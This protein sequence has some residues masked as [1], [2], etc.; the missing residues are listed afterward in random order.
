MVNIEPLLRQQPILILDG[1]LATELEARGAHLTDALWSAKILLEAP[2]LI[3]EVHLDYFR[4]GADVATTA[5][6]QASFAG[7]ER[8]GLT[9][10]QARALLQRS[11]QLAQ[12]AREL[13]W[14]DTGRRE[15]RI[16]PLVAASIGPYGAFLADGSEY[17]GQYGLSVRQLMDWHRPRL[18]VLL[19][20]GPDLLALET[21]PCPEEAEALARL[22]ED[23]P[24]A[25]AWL[26]FS[27]RDGQHLSQGELFSEG[28]RI[29]AA[30][31]QILAV[32][33]N[34]TPPEYITALLR[35]AQPLTSKPLL[36]YPNSGEGWD[37]ERRCWTGSGHELGFGALPRQWVQAGARLLGGCCRTGPGDV[38]TLR[39]DS[40]DGMRNWN[41]GTLP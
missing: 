10:E 41:R 20:A 22:L 2:A 35:V 8:R 33:V 7:L 32:G 26:S 16:Y 37:A 31:P 30:A 1:A 17:R 23:Y 39:E 4:A 36:A 25:R 29:G 40:V 15:G 24:A 27:C 11:V 13:F 14:A 9:R 12:E 19:D 18:E 34:C 3:R 6:Y 38:A 21:I 5:S 28:V